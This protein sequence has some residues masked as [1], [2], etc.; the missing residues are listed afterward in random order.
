MERIIDL[1][2]RD[3]FPGIEILFARTGDT[4][5]A[6]RKAPRFRRRCRDG[7]RPAAC[8][9]A[10]AN[11]YLWSYA[12]KQRGDVTVTAPLTADFLA[13]LVP[14]LGRVNA[15][16]RFGPG[17]ARLRRLADFACRLPLAS[18]TAW[19]VDRGRGSRLS[20]SRRNR[21]GKI[22][23]RTVHRGTLPRHP[24]CWAEI[25]NRARMRS[26]SSVVSLLIVASSFSSWSRLFPWSSGG[27]A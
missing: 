13:D 2:Y 20:G 22:R 3:R 24:R 25:F 11:F 7:S 21:P 4:R 1:F 8:W 23:R 10:T 19:I 9:C 26:R 12:Q 14:I 17:S 6:T 15:S 18:R 27:F 5:S 16:D